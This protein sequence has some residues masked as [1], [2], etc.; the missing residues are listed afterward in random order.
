MVWWVG[1]IFDVRKIDFRHIMGFMK[2][3]VEKR[4]EPIIQFSLFTQNKL[5][6]LYDVI[7]LL[8]NNNIHVMALTILDSTECAILRLVVDDPDAARILFLEHDLFY[9]ECRVVGLD[10]TSGSDLKHALGALLQA[11]INIHYT[12]SFLSRPR[13]GTAMILSLEDPEE[14]ARCLSCC[15]F[16]VLRQEDISR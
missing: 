4:G 9:N 10:L 5:G 16:K 14:A 11:E 8:N 12:Y 1:E 2:E 7:R 6:K 13:E 3:T 15:G